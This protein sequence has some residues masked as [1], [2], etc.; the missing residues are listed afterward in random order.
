MPREVL[1]WSVGEV[2]WHIWHGRCIVKEIRECPIAGWLD[3]ILIVIREHDGEPMSFDLTDVRELTP[4]A[5]WD[6][7]KELKRLAERT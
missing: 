1:D 6:A 4:I 3:P 5:E 2:C 7:S